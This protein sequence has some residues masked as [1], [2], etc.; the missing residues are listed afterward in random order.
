[1]FEL[2]N[3]LSYI[4]RE[5]TWTGSWIPKKED[6]ENKFLKECVIVP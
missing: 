6:V 4:L 5:L 3:E 1:V 2:A